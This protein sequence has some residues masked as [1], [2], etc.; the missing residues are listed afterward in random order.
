MTKTTATQRR[1]RKEDLKDPHRALT[2]ALKRSNNPSVAKHG[3]ALATCILN[4]WAKAQ[5]G[6]GLWVTKAT[7]GTSLKAGFTTQD[8]MDGLVDENWGTRAGTNNG[9][10]YCLVP[11]EHLIRYLRAKRSEEERALDLFANEVA[12]L[13]LDGVKDYMQLSNEHQAALDTLKEEY[14]T[15]QDLLGQRVTELETTMKAADRA[16]DD[17]CLF[18]KYKI[19]PTKARLQIH[20]LLV[21]ELMMLKISNPDPK[22]RTAA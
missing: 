11:S 7:I 15:S 5:T 10:R 1:K 4:Q 18:E 16:L 12:V 2:K 9:T 20:A 13:K 8:L 6:Q 17:L 14:S 22:Y 21:P 19:F 3:D